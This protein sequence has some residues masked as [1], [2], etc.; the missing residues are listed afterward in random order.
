MSSVAFK[1]SMCHL[2]RT[3]ETKHPDIIRHNQYGEF[4]PLS[5]VQDGD[6]VA[7]GAAALMKEDSSRPRFGATL[8]R[9]DPIFRQTVPSLASPPFTKATHHGVLEPLSS[10]V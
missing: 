4:H 3:T 9:C 10:R 1:S 2:L 5:D 8:T 7:E 6:A